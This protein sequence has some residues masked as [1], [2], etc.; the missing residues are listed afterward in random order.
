MFFVKIK[1]THDKS[2]QKH[3]VN[4]ANPNLK[5]KFSQF[6]NMKVQQM[7][8]KNP[9]KKHHIIHL[10]QYYPAI[11]TIYYNSQSIKNI[12]VVTQNTYKDTLQ[13]SSQ[14]D[15]S[16]HCNKYLNYL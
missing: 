16:Q 8:E 15:K 2:I 10:T 9:Y 7:S 4:H 12:T 3:T 6:Q 11:Y 14:C 5:K 1:S 13:Q